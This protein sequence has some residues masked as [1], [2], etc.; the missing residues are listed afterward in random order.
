ME[1][2]TF[3][4]SLTVAHLE[5]SLAFYEHLG[6]EVID[7]GHINEGFKDSDTMKWRILSA[8]SVK[9]GLFQGMFD[10]NIITFNPKDVISIQKRLKAADIKLIKETSESELMKSIMLSDPDGNQI[11]F[12][13]H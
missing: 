5:T 7:G 13:Q 11:M 12:D 1:L 8:D 3:S 4:L 6:F 10:A 2:G 9:I